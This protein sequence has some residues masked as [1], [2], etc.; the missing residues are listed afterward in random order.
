M[1]S[2]KCG[3]LHVVVCTNELKIKLVDI[4]DEAG[5]CDDGL[6]SI[7]FT[8]E[9]DGRVLG[10]NISNYAVIYCE[11]R[12]DIVQVVGK[13]LVGLDRVVDE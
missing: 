13:I 2:V 6:V 8:F 5:F 11:S 1:C 10:L 7:R 9:V 4:A 3:E 12:P